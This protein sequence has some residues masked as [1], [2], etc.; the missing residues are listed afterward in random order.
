[1]T[2]RRGLFWPLILITV[3][4][5]FLLANYGLI[6]PVSALAIL[7][8]WPLILILIGIDIAIG[9]RWPLAALAADVV[10]VAAGLALVA[11]Q[12]S[13]LPWSSF[14]V[15]GPHGNDT[16]GTSTVVVPRNVK[17]AD[18]TVGPAKSMTFHLNGG[19]GSFNVTGGASD[20][21]VRATSDQDNLSTKTTYRADQVDVRVDQSDRGFRLAAAPMRIDVQLASDLPTSF[22]M[23]AGAG[24]FVVDLR[25]VKVTDARINVGAASLRLV[26]PKPTGDVA[27]TVTA[28][29]SSV[30]IE[31]PDGTE[32]RVNTTGAVISVRSDNPR[33]TGTETA[34]YSTAK[35][36]VTVRVNAGASSLVIR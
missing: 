7:S 22:D 33:V 32:A 12:P 4:L 27:I 34:G 13:A 23:N 5:V 30:V 18:G 14:V 17:L 36:R 16:P 8:L 25:D 2:P 11:T 15:F 6:G 21:L 26:L 10:V 1:M 31:I 9:R 24:E 28:G 3:G 19:A 20:V 35:D 29:A